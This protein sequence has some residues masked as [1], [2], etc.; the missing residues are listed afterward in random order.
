MI[1]TKIS[2]GEQIRL[3]R[4]VNIIEYFKKHKNTSNILIGQVVSLSNLIKFKQ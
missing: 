3:N 1:K 2:W 4:L